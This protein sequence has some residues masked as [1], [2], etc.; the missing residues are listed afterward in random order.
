ML[1]FYIF[2]NKPRGL[3]VQ[4]RFV[5]TKVTKS[6]ENTKLGGLHVW[7]EFGR[8]LIF[9]YFCGARVYPPF[10]HD[11]PMRIDT[12]TLQDVLPEVFVGSE[13]DEPVS[14]SRVWLQNVRFDRQK[15]VD[16]QVRTPYYLIE[17]ES[18]TGK[19][20]L[21]SFVYGVRRDYRGHIF[22]NDTDIRKLSIAEWC[23]IR[24]QHLAYLP[25]EMHLFAELT[26]ME[27]VMIKNRL[28]DYCSEN[29]IRHMFELLE[30]EHKADVPAARLSVGQQQRVAIVRALCQPFDFIL[31]DEPVSHLDARNNRQV[32]ALIVNAAES[33]NAS[34][35]TTSVGNPLLLRETSHQSDLAS[36]LL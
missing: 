13:A 20:S 16:G 35:I 36:L 4:C 21:C 14:K 30:I 22:F 12:I 31:L 6:T 11:S 1:L 18:G 3:N 32:T 8:L 29:D 5:E 2:S 15:V 9:L 10:F 7:V 17:A 23:D 27:N 24:R 28:T 25:Q 26:A 33:R 19:S 34:I